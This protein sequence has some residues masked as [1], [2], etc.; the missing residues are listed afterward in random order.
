[1][2]DSVQSAT[3]SHP[4]ASSKRLLWINVLAWALLMLVSAILFQAP[5]LLGKAKELNDFDTFDIAGRLALEG[6][7]DHAYSAPLLF[8]AQKR[9]IGRSEFMPWAYPPQFTVIAMG[10][11][12]LPVGLAYLLFTGLTLA[13]YV[14]VLSRMAGP[15][16][17]GV[18]VAM[19]MTFVMLI[20]TGQNGFLTGALIG[21]FLLAF[22][23]RK[24]SAGLP[25]GLMVIKPHLAAG[26]ALLGLLGKRFAA[27]AIAAAVVVATS[28]LGTAILGVG[29]WQAFMNAAHEAATLL[30]GGH[31]PLFRMT[32]IYACL[33]SF[34]LDA[35]TALAL[36]ALGAVIAVL[37]I[38]GLWVKAKSRRLVMA[39][40]MVASLFISPYNYDYDLSILGLAIALVLPDL[41]ARARSWEIVLLCGL[42]WL[43]TGWGIVIYSI[44]MAG[45]RTDPAGIGNDTMYWSFPAIGLTI[46]VIAAA[47]ILDRSSRLRGSC[48]Q[49]DEQPQGGDTASDAAQE[50]HPFDSIEPHPAARFAG[51]PSSSHD[52]G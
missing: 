43:T 30:A 34:G 31:Y 38:V 14:L 28:L 33:R 48:C 1:M 52:L 17:P 27:L 8:E 9:M 12:L 44:A 18:V 25:L 50:S 37:S 49:G 46:L 24:A 26:V 4:N 32:S 7:A 23:Q 6:K 22:E 36:H 16:L 41:L 35:E 21:W 19:L 15:L 13:L 11:A 45:G 39:G 29:I 2:S 20:R 47:R 10:L 42:T 40:T 5:Q 3:A 51:H